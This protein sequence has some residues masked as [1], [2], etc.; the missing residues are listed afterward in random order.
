[1]YKS[2]RAIVIAIFAFAAVAAAFAI[3]SERAG[4]QMVSNDQPPA[5]SSGMARPP[6]ARQG[7][8]GTV[9]NALE[10]EGLTVILSGATRIDC[11]NDWS[12]RRRPADRSP[13]KVR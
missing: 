10:R 5:G 11:T 6:A 2:V 9:E 3:V 1:M 7:P 12:P 4:Q 13:P 8:G